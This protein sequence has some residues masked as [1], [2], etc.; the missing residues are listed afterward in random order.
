MLQGLAICKFYLRIK[1]IVDKQIKRIFMNTDLYTFLKRLLS[2]LNVTV[3][4]RIIIG[5]CGMN[6]ICTRIN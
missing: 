3:C 6:P 2:R 1:K 5:K 4:N